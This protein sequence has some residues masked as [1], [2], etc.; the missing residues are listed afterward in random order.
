MIRLK[1]ISLIQLFCLVALSQVGVRVL[2]MPYE[3][4]RE[5]G[6]DAWISVL[7]GGVIAQVIILII[8][9]LGK[10][11]ADRPLPEY[12]YA[13]TGRP[14]GLLINVLFAVYCVESSLL[15]VVSYS[16]VINRWV[17]ITTPWFVIIGVTVIVAA[18]IAS[19]SLQSLTAVTQTIMFMFFI[20]FIFV[21]IS[22]MGK[23]DLRH[24]L[25]IGTH[26]ITAILKDTLPAFWAYAGYELLL[27]VFPFVKC[28]RKRDILITMSLANGFTTFFYVMISIIV[29]YNFSENQL[30][31]IPEP[32]LYILRQFHW[33]VVQ[34]IDILFM[35]IWL[36]VTIVTVFVYLFL[37]ARYLA[38]TGGK[39]IRNH[40]VL[41]WILAA[42][43]FAV[44]VLG[45]DRQWIFQFAS[46]H[47]TASIIIIAIVPTILLLVAMARGKREA[48]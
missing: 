9:R 37:A 43:C 13:I 10:R 41:I 7:L 38:F 6:Y 21:F 16:D 25:P 15:V 40:P 35:T 4:S 45:S 47:N 34:S 14:L 22:G 48:G 46:F 5:S 26:G 24:L 19:S 28:K 3:E 32:M 31:S 36:S 30:N 17:L 27:Y 11:F 39:E 29:L 23:G 18:Y 33:P 2:T 42:I 1:E 44:G 12:I 8:Y 20:C